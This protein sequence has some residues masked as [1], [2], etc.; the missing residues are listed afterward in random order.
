MNILKERKR[1]VIST[2]VLTALIA[3]V[4]FIAEFSRFK[5]AEAVPGLPFGG[6]VLATI[7]CPCSGGVVLEVG[8]PS[9]GSYL[10][11][12]GLNVLYPFFQ[13]RSGVWVIGDY[14]PSVGMC[15]DFISLDKGVTCG[16]I[17]GVTGRINFMGTS[18]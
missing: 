3:L 12:P 2:A 14:F 7:P 9:V 10:Y 15:T 6:F 4:L 17:I 18:L 13:V 8:P 5:K 11:T 1:T 16:S